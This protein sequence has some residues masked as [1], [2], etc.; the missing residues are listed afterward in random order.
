MADELVISDVMVKGFLV[1]CSLSHGYISQSGPSL[2]GAASAAGPNGDLR[3]VLQKVESAWSANREKLADSVAKLN[4]TLEELLKK[5]DTME[6]DLGAVLRGGVAEQ[7]QKGSVLAPETPPEPAEGAPSGLS[8][9]LAAPSLLGNGDSEVGA[10]GGDP[11]WATAGWPS[12][13]QDS[14]AAPSPLMPATLPPLDL[15]PPEPVSRQAEIFEALTAFAGR[16]SEMTGMPE[17]QVFTLMAAAVGAAGLMPA[18]LL[19][20][21]GKETKPQQS[22]SAN[23]EVAPSQA[24]GGHTDGAGK[25][26]ASDVGYLTD[27]GVTSPN[28]GVSGVAMSPVAEASESPVADDRP[29]GPGDMPVDSGLEHQ[30][31]ASATQPETSV[32]LLPDAGGDAGVELPELTA[33]AEPDLFTAAGAGI[34]LPPLDAGGEWR[35]P[36]EGIPALE[37]PDLA[38]SDAGSLASDLSGTRDLPDLSAPVDQDGGV[39]A[40]VGAASMA[41][42]GSVGARGLGGL[43]SGASSGA[44]REVSSAGPRVTEKGREA[45]ANRQRARDVLE[46]NNQSEETR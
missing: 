7:L 30:V 38:A 1:S 23:D 6:Q 21:V 18:A 37:L 46:T 33:E 22:A 41:S 32:G 24:V 35:T 27:I 2:E 25:E 40:G 19:A 45:E 5:F 16:W 43:T 17:R 34:D 13:D 3:G 42:L 26:G 20:S 8:L 4:Q 12:L 44:G 29:L 11:P 15:A 14:A 10:G 39:V 9:A 36:A 31:G 28:D